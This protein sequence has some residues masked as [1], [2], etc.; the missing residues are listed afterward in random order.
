MKDLPGKR[1]VLS[2]VVEIALIV[3]ILSPPLQAQQISL[4]DLVTTST[5]IVKDGHPVTFA[6]HGFIE[7]KSLSE[8]FAYIGSR[9]SAG[10]PRAASTTGLGGNW[11]ANRCAVALRAGLS[12]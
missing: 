4:Q 6:L 5:T 8:L 2:V 12:R 7:F 1:R 11:H 9:L 3:A 10:R